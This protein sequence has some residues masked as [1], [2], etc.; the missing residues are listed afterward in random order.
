QRRRIQFPSEAAQGIYNATLLL[1]DPPQPGKLLEYRAPVVGDSRAGSASGETLLPPVWISVVGSNALWPLTAANAPESP[2]VL[3]VPVFGS[4]PSKRAQ[5][6]LPAAYLFLGLV[7]M[8]FSALSSFWYFF[9]PTPSTFAR[10]KLPLTTMADPAS[11]Y[12]STQ[13]VFFAFHLL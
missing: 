12:L 11:P 9:G 5:S 4:V 3:S 8:S 2:G 1:L 6:E 7:L 10:L 13:L